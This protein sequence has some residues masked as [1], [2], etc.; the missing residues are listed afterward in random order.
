[1]T[2][3]KKKPLVVIRELHKAFLHM[4]R[5][6][7]VLRGID[8]EI[9]EGEVVAIVGKSGAGKSTLLQ[10]IGTL[11]TPSSGIIRLGEKYLVGMSRAELADLRNRLI[12][13][14]FQFHHLLP[15]FNAL[16][17]VMMPGLI[18]G[19]PRPQIEKRARSLL[20]DVGLGHRVTHR[21][22]ELSGG[23]QQRVALARALL[24]EPKLIL[25]DEPTGNLDSATSDAIHKLFFEINATHGTTI[26]IVTHNQ[27]LA[28]SMPRIIRM[29]DGRIDEDSARDEAGAY[30]DGRERFAVDERILERSRALAEVTYAGFWQRFGVRVFDTVVMM[31]LAGGA[32]FAAAMF[33]PAVIGR[34]PELGRLGEW[35][36]WLMLFVT[37]HVLQLVYFA[38]SEAMGGATFGKLLFGLRVRDE[39]LEPCSLAAGLWRNVAFYLDG[40]LFGLIGFFAIRGSLLKQR[41][42][43]GLAQTVVVVAKTLPNGD[44]GGS[45]AGAALGAVVYLI[46]WTVVSF[47]LMFF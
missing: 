13:F 19:L 32:S 14:V 22:G 12:G 28:E 9:A 39:S 40:L 41:F 16:E 44:V 1:M 46:L 24:L 8:L 6:L 27:K 17:N 4:G 43:D 29:L 42:G 33:G 23:E 11:D 15:E 5:E 47:L 30:R 45:V 34:M 38:V 3:S 2:E 36:Y 35:W 20:D 26:V 25:A 37:S 18:Q 10:C 7:S 31:A 21:P